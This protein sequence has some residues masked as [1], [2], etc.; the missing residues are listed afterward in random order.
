M[1]Y[2]VSEISFKD[3]LWLTLTFIISKMKGVGKIAT[4][5]IW[6][7]EKR[8]DNVIDYTTNIEKTINRAIGMFIDRKKMDYKEGS[9]HNNIIISEV[10]SVI[11]K[12]ILFKL[13]NYF[14]KISN[15]YKDIKGKPAPNDWYEFV[16]YGSTNKR[17]IAIQKYGF[18]KR[19]CFV[20]FTA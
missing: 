5:G 1:Y 6:K 13:S 14:F 15:V 11:D 16:E 19:I 4:T 17:S 12:I 8:L 7:I 20:H 9:E 10:L 3:G 2:P 18:F